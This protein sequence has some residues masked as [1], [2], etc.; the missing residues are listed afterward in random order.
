MS[1]SMIARADVLDE[2][3]SALIA[4]EYV[5]AHVILGELK[6]S[7]SAPHVAGYQEL[8]RVF[9]S[10]E[11]FIALADRHMIMPSSVPIQQM[12]SA[13]DAIGFRES[14]FAVS[15]AVLNLLNERIQRAAHLMEFAHQAPE[16]MNRAAAEREEQ[17][18]RE[19]Q[20]R[21]ECGLDYHQLKLGMTIDRARTCVGTPYLM[22][23][24][25]RRGALMSTYQIGDRTVQVMGDQ[26]I[27]WAK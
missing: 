4:G 9:E 17:A 16:N 25:N 19:Q 24:W 14:N 21:T 1:I 26:I 7:P 20:L 6:D 23:V 15:D 22:N 2:F 5:R 12:E 11:A 27:G 3:E 10:C 18:A 13:Y 8:L